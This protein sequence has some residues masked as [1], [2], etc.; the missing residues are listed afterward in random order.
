MRASEI[1]TRKKNGRK[2]KVSQTLRIARVN[3]D[4]KQEQRKKGGKDPEKYSIVFS[5]YTET[6]PLKSY[7]IQKAEREAERSVHTNKCCRGD[8]SRDGIGLKLDGI[9]NQDRT[10]FYGPGGAHETFGDH[11]PYPHRVSTPPGHRYRNRFATLDEN[12]CVATLHN[13]LEISAICSWNVTS[14]L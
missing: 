13:Y 12:A 7:S 8:D 11:G 1:K 2:E 5:I 9:T 10:L 14:Q 3:D 6:H 4:V